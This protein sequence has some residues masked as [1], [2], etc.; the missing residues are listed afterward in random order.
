[1]RVQFRASASRS[2]RKR[3][4]TP[5][6]NG[7]EQTGPDRH[8]MHGR[9]RRQPQP[10]WPN[11]NSRTRGRATARADWRA[12]N[13][14]PRS[15]RRG[16]VVTSPCETSP[17]WRPALFDRFEE[18][19]CKKHIKSVR[20]VKGHFA[21]LGRHLTERR[22]LA[23]TRA[24]AS[25]RRCNGAPHG[26]PSQ[27]PQ[28]RR[29]CRRSSEFQTVRCSCARNRALDVRAAIRSSSSIMSCRSLRTTPR[30]MKTMRVR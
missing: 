23:A 22:R 25:L 19:D 13:T 8:V 1:M 20:V 11:H 14:P 15:L 2:R 21:P 28:R 9:S 16:W 24:A 18:S 17:W 4:E 3:G 30:V 7:A 12:Q 10:I 26:I 29:D 5:Q 27:A 6:P